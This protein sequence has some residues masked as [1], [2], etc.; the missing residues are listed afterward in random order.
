MVSPEA[1]RAAFGAFV[2]LLLAQTRVARVVGLVAPVG[3]AGGAA[4]GIDVAVE[5]GLDAGEVID[6]AC[7]GDKDTLANENEK[8]CPLSGGNTTGGGRKDK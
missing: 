5:F 3:A 4:L 1:R 6:A 7:A 8:G 2:A